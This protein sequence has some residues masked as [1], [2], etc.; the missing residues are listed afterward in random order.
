MLLFRP[1]GLEEMGLIYDSGM[2][3]FPPRLPD[4][5][6]F[7]PVTNEAY[8]KQIARDW[9]TKSGT[10]AGFVTRFA[11]D[12][13]YAAKFERHV[14]GDREHEELWVPAEELTD[15]NKHIG[16]AIEVI[17]AYF[18]EAYRGF[19]PE[20]FG[21]KGKDATAQCLALARTLPYSGFDVICEMA[22]NNKA[23]FLNFFF[24]EQ[25][26]FAVE[27]S[28]AERDAVLTKLRTVWARGERAALPLGVVR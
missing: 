6:I 3:A 1:V 20:A 27:L 18:G 10:L 9:N 4:Q 25:H 5:P 22:A 17:A 13:S 23:V 26:S 8:A 16:D 14:V 7:Y 19:V 28:D 15:F 21:L 24:W 12:D 2:R 11:V